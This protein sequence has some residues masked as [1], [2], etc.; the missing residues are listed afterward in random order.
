MV[1]IELLQVGE[2]AQVY[3][4]DACITN[5][6]YGDIGIVGEVQAAHVGSIDRE[7]L[8]LGTFRGIHLVESLAGISVKGNQFGI[9]REVELGVYVGQ[10]SH[11]QDH[12]LRLVCTYLQ[13]FPVKGVV[14]YGD[15]SQSRISREVQ[16]MQQIVVQIDVIQVGHLLHGEVRDIT[17]VE[18]Y[19]GNILGIAP[20]AH[21]ALLGHVTGNGSTAV[22]AACGSVD[23]GGIELMLFQPVTAVE[24]DIVRL[25][26]VSAQEDGHGAS[27]VLAFL[28]Q[29]GSLEF[30][31]RFLFG[32]RHGCE[33]QHHA[34]A[35]HH[36]ESE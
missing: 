12:E 29:Y 14:A 11:L 28:L 25:L 13:R 9:V 10:L 27:Y 31:K 6:E 36:H 7:S 16:L 34:C 5:V 20:N 18:V 19:H 35:G 21:D 17:S 30:Y 15:S 3:L 23:G 2:V 24:V 32:L 26:L 33:G 1:G 4:L 8:E 22:P